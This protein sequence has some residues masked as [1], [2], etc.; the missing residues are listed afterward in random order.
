MV[1]ARSTKKI[2]SQFQ[3]EQPSS[4]NATSTKNAP[5]TQQTLLN[6]KRTNKTSPS[7]TTSHYA[8]MLV[9]DDMSFEESIHGEE[10][11]DEF[12]VSLC[13]DGESTHDGFLLASISGWVG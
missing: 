13:N 3:L 6:A 12:S 4:K 5:K 10:S 1:D 7:S 9:N 2:L 8:P 11:S